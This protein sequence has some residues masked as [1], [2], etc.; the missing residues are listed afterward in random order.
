MRILHTSDWH[1]GR[2]I[3]GRSRADEHRAALSEITRIAA[4]EGVDLVVVAGD[5]FDTAAPTAEAERI[6]YRALLELAATGA[7]V[8][9]VAGNH[10]HPRRL[11]AVAPLLNLARVH[12]R[13]RL[14]RPDE[15]GVVDVTARG[16]EVARIALLPFLS[17]R[18][19]VTAD[20]L[21]ALDA[22]QHAG[23][24][25]ERCRQIVAAL[26]TGFTTDTVNIVVAHLT[27]VGGVLGGGERQAHS[28]FDYVVPTQ[29]FPATSHYVALG[30]LH[31][32]Q[33]IPG[34]CPIRYSGSPLQ[35]DFGEARGDK[36]VTIVDATPGAPA[37][38]R[39]VRL[40]AGRR[41][42]TVSGTLEELAE[43]DF[44]DDYLRIV[45][46]EPARPGLADEARARFPHAVDVT[47]AAAEL[48]D[49]PGDWSIAG[50][51]RSPSDLFS[52]YLTEIGHDDPALGTL[53]RQLLEEAHA[54]DPA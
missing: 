25:A 22:D 18:S 50:F 7:D 43:A 2:T 34:P 24:Y 47:V 17:Q 31:R 19:I 32:P 15:G 46:E 30:H 49:D 28:I 42:R 48:R 23:R 14:A 39:N 3:R 29:V 33:T 13:A 16:G 35:L 36:V 21:M 41:L 1:V 52:E 26:T 54:S 6:V 44:G 9:V 38:I 5:L 10:D 45:L 53:F 12:T 4:D 37:Q 27:V 40:R 8:V 20:D 11:E 51:Q